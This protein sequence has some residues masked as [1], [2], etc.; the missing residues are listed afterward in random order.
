MK[1]N[2]MLA[3]FLQDQAKKG[4]LSPKL[5]NVNLDTTARVHFDEAIVGI[6]KEIA[7]ANKVNIID[8]NSLRIQGVSDLNGGRIP[9]DLGMILSKI[10]L[11]YASV[12]KT[13]TTPAD[14]LV[15]TLK[16]DFQAKNFAAQ[17]LNARLILSQSNRVLKNIPIEFIANGTELIPSIASAYKLTHLSYISGEEAITAEIELPRVSLDSEKRH[18]V[19]VSFIGSS[20]INF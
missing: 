12:A 17:L 5:K 13:V 4:L 16:F 9:Y 3:A 20:I 19:E 10:A 18:F 8:T 15:P 2:S 7:G 6:K 14:D 1:K 11:G